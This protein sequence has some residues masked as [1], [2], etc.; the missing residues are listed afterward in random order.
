MSK[1]YDDFRS[2]KIRRLE[3]YELPDDVSKKC[4]RFTRPR[5]LT[6]EEL[7]NAGES[8]DSSEPK[9]APH[10]FSL[11]T[12]KVVKREDSRDGNTT[13]LLIELQDG[14]QVE[15]VLMRYDNTVSGGHRRTTLCVSSQVGCAMACTFCATG[16]MGILGSLCSG[17]ILEQFIWA[18]EIDRIRNVV[19]MGMGEPLQ[20]Y[21]AVLS[22]INAMTDSSRFS[23]RKNRVT[24]STV[25][26][27]NR[28]FQLIDTAPQVT[29][30]LSLHAPTQEMREK[31][32]PSARQYPLDKLM[33][34][35]DYYFTATGNSM[36]LEYVMLDDINC[37]EQ[38]AHELGQLLQGKHV[39][40]NL[41]PFNPVLTKAQHVAP[42]VETCE[43]FAS[44][45]SG[46]YGVFT[47][48]RKEL[49][50]DISGACGQLAVETAKKNTASN[51]SEDVDDDFV[52]NGLE[53]IVSAIGA[54][55]SQRQTEEAPTTATSSLTDLEDIVTENSTKIKSNTKG[56]RSNA[57]RVSVERDQDEETS[58][59][60]VAT[61]KKIKAVKKQV[62]VVEHSF[63]VLS[64]GPINRSAD[65]FA[66][67]E[68]KTTKM[69][70]L[71]DRGI[72][73]EV[74]Q[75]IIQN[76]SQGEQSQP[77]ALGM[78]RVFMPQTTVPQSGPIE[79]HTSTVNPGL[80]M[81]K[82]NV[83]V[84]SEGNVITKA[85]R[86]KKANKNKS[87]IV[88][89]TS[90]STLLTPRATSRKHALNSQMISL[91][92]IIAVGLSVLVLRQVL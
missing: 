91:G 92:I 18:N 21:D 64:A 88:Q 74:A 59:P 22:S 35:I 87:I 84:D 47:T 42:S 33:E 46:Q 69:K 56:R 72:S 39:M 62:D 12:S 49:G 24:L 3:D 85:K 70:T 36:L 5:L 50:Q 32:V 66:R 19:F 14:Q 81:P 17:E 43:R 15:S 8:T 1:L 48:L 55:P 7:Q 28:M 9:Y 61:V 76:K 10:E 41:I 4:Y 73:E 75:K 78:R 86:G 80:R 2:G 58:A 68:T 31:I 30:A 79:K 54:M 34:A 57:I 26:V 16:T 20:N 52:A 40:V 71:V 45:V 65:E 37:S 67:G 82:T 27:I 13:K 90:D 38:T 83:E 23:L 44:I 11:M 53:G 29:L 60:A 25:G 51:K 89:D 63:A 77:Q 6:A